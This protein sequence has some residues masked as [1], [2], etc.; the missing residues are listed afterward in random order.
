MLIA[1]LAEHPAHIPTLAAWAYQ[2][3]G[4]LFPDETYATLVSEFA[5]RAAA[6]A[7]PATYIALEQTTL[8]GM[9]SLAQEDLPI[10]PELSPWLADVYVLPEYRQRGLGAQ[11]IRTILLAA[12]RLGVTQLYLFTADK[13]EFYRRLGWQ[14]CEVTMYRGEQVTIMSYQL[15]TYALPPSIPP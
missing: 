12:E 7:I 11:L 13:I 4:H 6:P 15:R 8:L 10:R 9:A 3:W 1:H 5:E 2:E 14:V